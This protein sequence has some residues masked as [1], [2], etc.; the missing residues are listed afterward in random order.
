MNFPRVPSQFGGLLR[1]CG[2]GG[3]FFCFRR[4]LL[5]PFLFVV[6]G[7]TSTWLFRCGWVYAPKILSSPSFMMGILALNLSFV[8]NLVIVFNTFVS[9]VTFDLGQV[10]R[11][12]VI[13]TLTAHQ[14]CFALVLGRSTCVGVMSVIFF[15]S[16]L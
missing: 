8:D 7:P 1:F 10:A 5:C 6:N 4:G 13:F 14:Y 15:F 12:F 11:G 2:G 16:A 3:L 9:S